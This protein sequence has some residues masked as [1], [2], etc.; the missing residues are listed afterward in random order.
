MTSEQ[1][2]WDMELRGI[3]SANNQ[4]LEYWREQ[5][6]PSKNGGT[7]RGHY[8]HLRPHWALSHCELDLHF[9]C[10]PEQC[11]QLKKDLMERG[12]LDYEG[13]GYL[14]EGFDDR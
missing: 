13:T 6:D 3:V 4:I 5:M 9:T 1:A 14:C 12:L 2:L 8:I 7:V 10:T 11:R